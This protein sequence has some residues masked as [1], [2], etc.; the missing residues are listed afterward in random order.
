[1][2]GWLYADSW[3]DVTDLVVNS[4][5]PRRRTGASFAGRCEL[6]L[7]VL[8]S[9]VAQLIGEVLAAKIVHGPGLEMAACTKIDSI[10]PNRET[11]EPKV[12]KP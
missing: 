11:Q 8:Q 1:M 6:S 12:L 4:A 5:A 2:P 7:P 9:V 10:I 3:L